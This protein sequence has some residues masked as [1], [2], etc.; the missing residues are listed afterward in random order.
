MKVLA[1]SL[2]LRQGSFNGKLIQLVIESAEKLGVELELI[3]LSA[4][5]LPAY[6]MDIQNTVGFPKAANDL[7]DKLETAQGIMLA[8]P[9]YNFSYPGHFKN[10]FDWISRYQPMPWANKAVLLL[11]ASPSLVGGNRGLWH[12]RVPFEACGAFVYPGMFSLA[13]AHDAFTESGALKD[14]AMAK[15]LEATVLSYIR[16]AEALKF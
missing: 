8:S 3:D 6:N 2:S 1:F 10:T 11:S 4:Y 15:R 12:L 13:S 16:F 9:E 5:E 14:E 7:K